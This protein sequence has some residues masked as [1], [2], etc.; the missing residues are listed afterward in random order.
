MPDPR[1]PL[2]RIVHETRL[3]WNS[4][5]DRP[6]IIPAWDDRMPWQQQLDMAMAAAVEAAVLERVAALA[7]EHEATYRPEDPGLPRLTG[8]PGLTKPGPDP[9]GDPFADLIREPS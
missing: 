7:D 6:F 5:R 9:L 3:A 1:E 2:G 8:V 4:R